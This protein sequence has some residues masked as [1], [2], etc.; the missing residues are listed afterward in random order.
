MNDAIALAPH[1]I[2]SKG[3]EALLALVGLPSRRRSTGELSGSAEEII[4]SIGA[5]LDGLLLRAV[6]AQ[7]KKEFVAVRTEVFEPYAG[8]LTSLARLVHI[9][10]PDPVIEH[11][12]SDSFCELE[13]DFREHGSARFGVDAK[14]Q[15]MFTVWTLRRTSR[16]IAKVASSG[17]VPARLKEQDEKL[18]SDFGFFA[19]WTQFH[20]DCM[21]ASIRHDEP[22]QLEVLPEIIDGLRA[23]VNAYGYARQGLTLRAPAEEPRLQPCEWDEEDQELLDSSMADM[24]ADALDD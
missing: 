10:V 1:E 5:F 13:S 2:G 21:L 9:L 17:P 12:I 8:A 16:L 4:K 19:A 7:T 22:I 11:I 6:A 3:L 24:A 18:A 14:D 23:A 15:A 20:L